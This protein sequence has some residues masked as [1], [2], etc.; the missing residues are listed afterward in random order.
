[1]SSNETRHLR[2]DTINSVDQLSS[3]V[4]LALALVGA[5]GAVGAHMLLG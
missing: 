4:L 3:F 1:M 5:V 2:G